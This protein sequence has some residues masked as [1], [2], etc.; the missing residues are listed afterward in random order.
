[1]VG[2]VGR[3]WSL[4]LSNPH[5]LSLTIQIHFC[6]T[7]KRWLSPLQGSYLC[8]ICRCHFS[9]FHFHIFSYI[10]HNLFSMKSAYSSYSRLTLDIPCESFWVRFSGRE[11]SILITKECSNTMNHNMATT[12]QATVDLIAATLD[13]NPTA[14]RDHLQVI[15]N[16][17]ATHEFQDSNPDEARRTWQV[18]LI[19]VFQRVAFVDADNGG[20][21]D[22]ANWCLRQALTLLQVYPEDTDLISCE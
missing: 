12:L 2:M 17:T 21:P 10:S 9:H 13:T 7:S 15:R 20:V 16:I 3:Y 6:R 11:P 14:W 4:A 22:I 8:I 19:R 1:M 18:P 5:S